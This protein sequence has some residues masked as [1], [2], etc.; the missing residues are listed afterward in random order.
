MFSGQAQQV[1]S[2][3]EKKRQDYDKLLDYTRELNSRLH[4]MQIDEAERCILAS[5][6]LLALRLPNFK[7]Y[8][9]TEDNQTILANRMINDVMDW[10]KKENVG[11][12]KINIIE[13]KYSTIRGMFVQDSK[14]NYL[15]DLISD[16]DININAFEKTNRYYDVLGQLFITEA[17]I[18]F[19]L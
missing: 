11:S 6:I 3:D 14:H 9:K 10:L 16:M 1:N 4:K 17:T 18:I 8:Y 13:S 5:C 19:K 7:S 15:R 12:E 2:S